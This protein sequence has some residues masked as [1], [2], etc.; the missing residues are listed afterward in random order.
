ME[1]KEKLLD[2]NEVVIVMDES[3]AEHL[4]LALGAVSFGC[5]TNRALKNSSACLVAD[6]TITWEDAI[7]TTYN[8][9]AKIDKQL[10]GDS[11]EAKNDAN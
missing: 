5:N 8:L 4:L 2:V 10:H 6:K 9:I 3:A 1:N 7:N 11:K